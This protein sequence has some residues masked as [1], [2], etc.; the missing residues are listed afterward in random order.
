MIY[1]K[2]IFYLNLVLLFFN[3][4]LFQ[5]NQLYFL[6]FR[7]GNSKSRRKPTPVSSVGKRKSTRTSFKSNSRTNS[8]KESP[9]ASQIS[10][11]KP[12]VGTTSLNAWNRN[13]N[14]FPRWKK[15]RS[16]W[17]NRVRSQ[18]KPLKRK[19]NNNE[20]NVKSFVKKSNTQITQLQNDS[21]RKDVNKELSFQPIE[22]NQNTGQNIF[23]IQ[24]T[25]VE[26]ESS[27]FKEDIQS[28]FQQSSQPSTQNNNIKPNDFGSFIAEVTSPPKHNENLDL[29][30][31]DTNITDI[32]LDTW[33]PNINTIGQT[34]LDMFGSDFPETQNQGAKS[35]LNLSGFGS[36]SSQEKVQPKIKLDNFGSF[37]SVFPH[38]KSGRKDTGRTT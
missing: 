14:N 28:T 22:I 5:K 7:P 29:N 27:L 4:S 33:P 24:Q 13:I 34:K 20:N 8:A 12:G 18:N 11:R 1:S 21:F 37:T 10:N 36:F 32:S 38:P 19:N 30:G 9:R 15:A 23:S 6:E 16:G 17:N 35:K 3:I 25:F 26:G 2:V 31:F